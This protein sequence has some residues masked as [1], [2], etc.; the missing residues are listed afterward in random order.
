MDREKFL[1]NLY[2]LAGVF[3]ASCENGL[4]YTA[5][6]P[7]S[8]SSYYKSASFYNGGT[9]FKMLGSRISDTLDNALVSTIIQRDT[10][11]R[12]S[13]K[14]NDNYIAYIAEKQLR[15]HRISLCQIAAWCFRFWQ[16]DFPSNLSDRDIT[17][18]LIL[19]FLS[20]Y[21]ISVDEYKGLFSFDNSTI[22][23]LNSMITGIQLREALTLN[24]SECSSDI[25]S[26][27][28]VDYMPIVKQLGNEDFQRLLSLRGPALTEQRILEILKLND[29]DTKKKVA[30]FEG[31]KN[32]SVNFAWFVGATGNNDD[33]V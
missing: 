26:G 1:R 22:E 8:I 20:Q 33:G 6:F 32:K 28:T 30:L 2:D 7:F 4:K 10:D 14:F 31:K 19:A 18:A 21:N 16:L 9:T 12:N 24:N 15:G 29:D 5:L 23:T 3:D 25:Q 17:D 11:D 27:V 13:L